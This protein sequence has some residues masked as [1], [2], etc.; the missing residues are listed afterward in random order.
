M[1]AAQ[2][3]VKDE[4]PTAAEFK[5]LVAQWA[6]KIGVR[7]RGVYL[8]RMKS[9]WASGSTRGRLCFSTEILGESKPFRDF[10]IVHELV[11]LLVPNHGK[12][13]RGLLNAYVPG[14]D[15]L[16]R[17]NNRGQG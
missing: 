10:V 6:E 17:R 3:R 4:G 16:L 8:Q 1:P 15:V 11:H 12:L 2:R 5:A 9:K 7:P 14:W 13:F